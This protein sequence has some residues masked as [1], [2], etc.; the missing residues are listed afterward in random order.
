MVF[1]RL[2]HTSI[3]RCDDLLVACV[4]RLFSGINFYTVT[5]G[6]GSGSSH[7]AAIQRRRGERVAAAYATYPSEIYPHGL[8]IKYS[9]SRSLSLYFSSLGLPTDSD[10][11]DYSKFVFFLGVGS[12]A[13]YGLI[14]N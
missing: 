3:K 12:T 11:E 14:N 6:E 7:P 8:S 13:H 2:Y 9:F 5:F 1:P 4:G 10:P